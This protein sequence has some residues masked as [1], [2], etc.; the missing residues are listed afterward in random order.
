MRS[1][2]DRPAVHVTALRIHNFMGLS[3]FEIKPGKVTLVRGS[4][5]VG[6]T[7]ILEAFK[8]V[9]KGGHDAS[10][11]RKGEDGAELGLVL[12][13]GADIQ[14]RI[15]QGDS[16]TQVDHPDFGRLPSSAKY[17]GSLCDA[18]AV[19]PVEFL[20]AKPDKRVELLL[21]AIPMTVAAVDLAGILELCSSK[22]D[23]S[24]HA[25]QVIAGIEKDLYDQRTGVNRAAKEKRA[26]ISEMRRALP[27]ESGNAE[28]TELVNTEREYRDIQAS[29]EKRKTEV[30][31]IRA[32]EIGLIKDEGRAFAAKHFAERD[33]EIEAI[34]KKYQAEVDAYAESKQAEAAALNSKSD[35][36]LQ[37]LAEERTSQTQEFESRI[38]RLRADRDAFVRSRDARIAV[39]KME[40]GAAT[41]ESDSSAFSEALKMLD[42]VRGNLTEQLP[43]KGVTLRDGD[44]YVDGIPFDRV[45]ESRRMRLAIEIAMLRSGNLPFIVV[46]GAEALDAN[47]LELL[48]DTAVEMGVQMVLGLVADGPNGEPRPLEIKQIA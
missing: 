26:T 39:A 33:R 32:N 36:S 28:E 11:I 20:T 37:E 45:N 47:N 38:A 2:N 35:E 6:K 44:I 16:K 27:K 1:N 29:W 23:L 9:L 10:L 43:I 14:K 22:P 48:A 25:L 12:S 7:S 41:L 5:G 17:L 30:I 13:D 8:A 18:F 46:D 34:R 24:R 40:S 21:S 19:N 4:N 31:E 42:D 3:D 15:R